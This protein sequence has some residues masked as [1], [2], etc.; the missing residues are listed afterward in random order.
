MVPSTVTSTIIDCANNKFT[1]DKITDYDQNGEI[2]QSFSIQPSQLKWADIGRGSISESAHQNFCGENAIA[3]NLIPGTVKSN[4]SF[5][6][7]DK[8]GSYYWGEKGKVIYNDKRY[9][10]VLYEYAKASRDDFLDKNLVGEIIVAT[11]DCSDK[12]KANQVRTFYIDDRRKIVGMAH[13]D[14]VITLA[15]DSGGRIIL[16]SDCKGQPIT[17][18]VATNVNNNSNESN[19]SV[20]NDVSRQ[21]LEKMSL[22][23]NLKF[24][25]DAASAMSFPMKIDNITTLKSL[26]CGSYDQRVTALYLYHL[27][28]GGSY[29]GVNQK[30]MGASKKWVVHQP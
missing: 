30:P 18:N 14:R 7:T 15:P 1:Y 28:G 8:S 25:Q 23:Q 9:Y 26:T 12:S 19:Y 20:P 22:K 21:S 29:S 16:E 17:T 24:C 27:D 5:I 2:T 11:A 10:G 13:Q 4:L 3:L 6:S